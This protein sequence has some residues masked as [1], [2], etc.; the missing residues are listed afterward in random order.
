MLPRLSDGAIR[1]HDGWIMAW[2]VRTTSGHIKYANEEYSLI[3]GVSWYQPAV[4]D[5]GTGGGCFSCHS[6]RLI[7]GMLPRGPVS[8]VIEIN[9]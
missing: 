8:K 3:D 6:L 1:S 2:A 7:D 5:T 4:M 9:Q